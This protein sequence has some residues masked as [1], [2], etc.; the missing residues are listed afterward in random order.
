ML[1]ESSSSLRVE[2][3]LTLARAEAASSRPVQYRSASLE[4][5]PSGFNWSENRGADQPDG[6]GCPRSL[7]FTPYLAIGS[8]PV[9]TGPDFVRQ[10]STGPIVSEYTLAVTTLA[11]APPIG[12]LLR[13]AGGT[14]PDS[15]RIP[16]CFNR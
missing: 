9:L 7:Y 2:D 3:G 4:G 10:W 11:A 12:T 6:C 13:R 16:S 15:V 1:L 5:M 14:R 8:P